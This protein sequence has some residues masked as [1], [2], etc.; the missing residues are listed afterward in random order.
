LVCKYQSYHAHFLVAEDGVAQ[1]LPL[2]FGDLLH[3]FGF[4]LAYAVQ[5]EFLLAEG[6]DHRKGEE[7]GKD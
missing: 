7:D 3:A 4:D 5:A 2:Y 1:S 6:L